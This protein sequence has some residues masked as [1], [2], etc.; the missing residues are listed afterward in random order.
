MCFYSI[1][2]IKTFRTM[3]CKAVKYKPVKLYVHEENP[4]ICPAQTIKHLIAKQQC[5]P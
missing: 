5:F 3:L 4:N 1:K 2:I